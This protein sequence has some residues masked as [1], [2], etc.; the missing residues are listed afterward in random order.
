MNIPVHGNSNIKA[1]LDAFEQVGNV[2]ISHLIVHVANKQS[3]GRWVWLHPVILWSSKELN[4]ETSSAKNC[5][6]QFLTGLDCSIQVMKL[7]ITKAIYYKGF[8]LAR[9]TIE[10]TK[11][12]YLTPL[13]VP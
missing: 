12:N 10:L 11:C 13:I 1:V 6:V 2:V 5:I 3:L 8:I 9:D 7:N 4:V